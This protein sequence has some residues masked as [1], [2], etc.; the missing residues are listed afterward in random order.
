[1]QL[2]YR[3][4]LLGPWSFDSTDFGPLLEAHPGRSLSHENQE[5][6]GLEERWKMK[7]QRMG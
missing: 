3:F 4:R 5:R 2:S 7:R 1:M 6:K